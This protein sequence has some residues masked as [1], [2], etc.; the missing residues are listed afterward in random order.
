MK[1]KEKKREERE[2]RALER[3]QLA[4]TQ[5]QEDERLIEERKN[6]QLEREKLLKEEEEKSRKAEAEWEQKKKDREMMRTKLQELSEKKKIVPQSKEIKETDLSSES[7]VE[8]LFECS[9]VSSDEELE[10]GKET[11]PR[12]KRG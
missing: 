9:D 12:K 2:K 1:I 5:R 11:R 6:R 7:D 4:E 3:K 10:G 8:Y